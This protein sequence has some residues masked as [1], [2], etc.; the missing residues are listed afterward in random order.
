MNQSTQIHSHEHSRIDQ[1][2]EPKCLIIINYINEI[3]VYV[4]Q[5]SGTKMTTSHP[6]LAPTRAKHNGA[7]D[8]SIGIV[9]KCNSHAER[10]A[11]GPNYIYHNKCPLSIQEDGKF[12][13]RI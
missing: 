3:L 4:L 8:F 1:Q 13:I 2:L 7:F 6:Q 9:G 12:T 5:L 10:K 11:P